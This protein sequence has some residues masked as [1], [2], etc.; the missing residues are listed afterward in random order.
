MTHLKLQKLLFYSYGA[1][2]AYG[3]TNELGQIV[4]EPWDHGPVNREVWDVYKGY[5][6][7]PLPVPVDAGAR[8]SLETEGLLRDVLEVYGRLGAWTIRCETHLETPWVEAYQRHASTIPDDAMR[9]HFKQRFRT[10]H[11]QLPAHLGG[12]GSAALDFIPPA[13]FESLASAAR[14][15]RETSGPVSD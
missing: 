5:G 8:Y 15:L 11:V 10:G 3:G 1:S 14:L 6:N 13:R 7:A 12:S 4:F 2:L 9:A